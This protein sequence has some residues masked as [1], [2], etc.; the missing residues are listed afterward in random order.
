MSLSLAEIHFDKVFQEVT[1]VIPFNPAWVDGKDGGLIH[2][3]IG[4]VAPK[5]EEGAIVKSTD[6]DGRK[7][8]IVGTLFGNAVVFEH[9]SNY[10]GHVPPAIGYMHPRLDN[11]VDLATMRRWIGVKDNIGT[12]VKLFL[13]AADYAKVENAKAY[14]AKYKSPFRNSYL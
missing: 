1:T 2:A 9:G 6:A 8:L 5:V 10:Q 12:H 3:V 14:R 13:K 11:G 4:D 7:I